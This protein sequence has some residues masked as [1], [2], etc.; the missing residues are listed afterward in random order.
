MLL[1]RKRGTAYGSGFTSASTGTTPTRRDA[2]LIMMP[3]SHAC[4]HARLRIDDG[5]L[6]AWLREVR[7]VDAGAV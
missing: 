4:Q 5:S 3:R 7:R 6:C 1:S 2:T